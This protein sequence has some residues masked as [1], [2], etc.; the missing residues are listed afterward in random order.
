MEYSN[1]NI[2]PQPKDEEID[3]IDLI[4]EGFSHWKYFA[5]SIAICLL[6]AFVYLKMAAPQYTVFG[7]IQLQGDDKRNQ[8]SSQLSMLSEMG[9][10]LG[11]KQA[12]DEVMV[13]SSKRLVG[14]LVD[15]LNL[16]TA[17]YEKKGLK[18]IEL[19]KKMPVTVTLSP[20][21]QQNLQGAIELKLR[22]NGAQY[23]IDAQ[24]TTANGKENFSSN[25]SSLNRSIQ[26]PWGMLL[27][28][29]TGTL[30]DNVW[31]KISIIPRVSAIEA[32]SKGINVALAKKESNIIKLSLT[33]ANTE[34]GKDIINTLI[35]LYN[36]DV[37]NDK[38]KTAYNTA[39]FIDDRL[40]KIT[41][42]LSSVEQGVEEYKKKNNLIDVSSQAQIALGSANDY[43]R[44]AAGV[45]LQL[46]LIDWV[47]GELK[48]PENQNK[49]LP[50][51]IGIENASLNGA[52]AGYNQLLL[53][54]MKLQRS[55]N[56][57]NPVLSQL[58]EQIKIAGQNILS[59]TENVRKG[60]VL[61]KNDLIQKNSQFLSKVND[62]PTIERQYTEIARQQGIKQN[63]YLFLLQKREE[64]ALSL[65]AR[66]S[67]S[68]LVDPAYV[69]PIP[70]SPRR[71]ITLLIALIAGIALAIAYLFIHSIIN[72][73]INDKKEIEK[74]TALPVLG[75]I[76]LSD[77][78]D[79]RIV[80][81]EGSSTPLSEMFRMLRTNLNFLLPTRQDK[82]VL[83]TSS[84]AG[85][86]KTFVSINLA[87]SLALLKKRV[88]AVGLDIRKPRLADYLH[89]RTSRGGVTNFLTDESLSVQQVI[90]PSKIHPMLDVL[91]SGP[92]PPNPAE[93]LLNARIEE[94]FA[95]LNEIYDYIIVDT[96][97]IGLV[98][99]TFSLNRVA[100]AVV[101]VVYQGVTP[102]EYI[103]QVNAIAAKKKLTNISFVLNGVD[104]KKGGY[105][106]GYGYGGYGK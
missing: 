96:A 7:S 18:Y 24:Y 42:E 74:L 34:K 17:Y 3:L 83:V 55:A 75:E 70:V 82:V 10:S 41:K 86:G 53:E 67:A 22:K 51:N 19:Y 97:P 30:K 104:L 39:M 81:E 45:E 46:N 91:P 48:N 72:N 87:L 68:K 64:N 105:K 62:I 84:I 95:Q 71:M 13:I 38:N 63:L 80:V 33:T 66:V 73:K 9:M 59:S 5:I 88:I 11:S 103:Q 43:Q 2:N 16:Q 76:G 93:L 37:L 92:V 85:E 90:V 23:A 79:T 1:T 27:F 99:D 54:K 40:G 69:S 57:N 77:R 89:V 29:E 15:S 100:N 26:M 32:Y 65:A 61:T 101:F 12:D 31:Y 50:S 60:L 106:K 20:A 44:Q 4:K 47:E 94:M 21:L 78:K 52:I 25:E 28:E 58:D 36:T 6:L 8:M 49:T 102:R 35:Y 56:E 14:E 98:A